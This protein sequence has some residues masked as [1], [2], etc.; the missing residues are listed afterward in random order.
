MTSFFDFFSFNNNVSNASTKSIHRKSMKMLEEIII[1]C[2]CEPDSDSQPNSILLFDQINNFDTVKEYDINDIP[3]LS[4]M[5]IITFPSC[6]KFLLEYINERNKVLLEQYKD[7]REIATMNNELNKKLNSIK[8]VLSALKKCKDLFADK[9]NNV[10]EKCKKYGENNNNKKLAEK[11]EMFNRYDTFIKLCN[12]NFDKFDSLIVSIEDYKNKIPTKDDEVPN[13]N[14]EIPSISNKI[15]NTM[16]QKLTDLK[17]KRKDKYVSVDGIGTIDS[18]EQVEFDREM[19]NLNL[20]KQKQDKCLDILLATVNEIQTNAKL[21]GDELTKQEE[22]IEN[23]NKT[24]DK[25]QNKLDKLNKNLTTLLKD[26]PKSN[27]VIY[28]IICL[29]ILAIVGI[30]LTQSNVI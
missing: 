23:S 6:C 13:A 14:A 5:I 22:M 27:V 30:T 17:K 9:K 26:V 3:I 25:E 7:T 10:E 18:S 21:I 24:I 12:E 11:K 15:K 20:K 8:N 1:K 4:N 19:D 29:L 2:G 16:R 28:V